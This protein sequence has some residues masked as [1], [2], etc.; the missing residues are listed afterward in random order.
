MLT[1]LHSSIPAMVNIIGYKVRGK[2]VTP[3]LIIVLLLQ[4]CAFLRALRVMERMQCLSLRI[5]IDLLHSDKRWQERRLR[6][7]ERIRHAAHRF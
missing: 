2:S 1:L 7:F 5:R 6:L 4:M 3:L